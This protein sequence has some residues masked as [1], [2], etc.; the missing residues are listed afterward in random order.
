MVI[1]DEA[2]QSGAEAY[3]K[4]LSSLDARYKLG[5][6]ATPLRKD[7]MNRILFNLIGPVTVKTEAVGLIPR[8]EVLETGVKCTKSFYVGLCNEIFAGK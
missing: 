3:S 6:S 2:H 1:V 8:I 5:L 7:A 4:F